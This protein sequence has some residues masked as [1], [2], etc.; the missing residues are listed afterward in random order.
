MPYVI[1]TDLELYTLRCYIGPSDRETKLYQQNHDDVPRIEIYAHLLSEAEKYETS[2]CASINKGL[3]IYVKWA[4]VEYTFCI[5]YFVLFQTK[6]R[7][8]LTALCS[9]WSFN[10]CVILL[11]PVYVIQICVDD[12]LFLQCQIHVHLCSFSSFGNPTLHCSINM[13]IGFCGLVCFGSK[14]VLIGFICLIT[15]NR[16]IAGCQLSSPKRYG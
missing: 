2:I 9:P 8:S 7:F 6:G 16:M 4:S 12:D 15:Y 10:I 5:N 1:F 14:T 11:E 3:V 13:P